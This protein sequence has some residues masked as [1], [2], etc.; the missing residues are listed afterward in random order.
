M[1]DTAVVPYNI[2]Y[3]SLGIR[4]YETTVKI[5]SIAFNVPS[6]YEFEFVP[7]DVEVSNQYGTFSRKMIVSDGK[8]VM[9]RQLTINKGRYNTSEAI[10]FYDFIKAVAIADHQKVVLKDNTPW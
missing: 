2:V 10:G 4:C 1:D 9:Q 7:E 8:L 3:D 5:D 6:G